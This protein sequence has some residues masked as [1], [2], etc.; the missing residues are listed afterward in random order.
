MNVPHALLNTLLSASVLASVF[1]DQR[2]S[3]ALIL[4]V[5]AVTTAFSN[6]I[7]EAFK[8]FGAWLGRKWNEP[9][10]KPT[11]PAVAPAPPEN[12]HHGGQ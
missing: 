8:S 1:T 2:V 4:C 11:T 12:E 9:A 3:T 7:T 6:L 10:A 5:V